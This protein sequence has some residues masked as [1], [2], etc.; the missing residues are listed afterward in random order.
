MFQAFMRHPTPQHHTL[1]YVEFCTPDLASAKEFYES[2]FGWRFNDYGPEYAGIVEGGGEAG[3][4]S[5]ISDVSTPPLPILFSEDLEVS[6]QSVTDAGGKVT[7]GPYAFPGGRRFH[8]EDPAG[9]HL[10][11]WARS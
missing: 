3:G 2:A 10:A 6:L 11:V 9:N 5:A 7:V 8:F 4:L 1:D